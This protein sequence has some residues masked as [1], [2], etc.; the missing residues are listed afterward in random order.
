MKNAQALEWTHKQQ[1]IRRSFEFRS[2]FVALVWVLLEAVDYLDLGMPLGTSIAMVDL[3]IWAVRFL[4]MT[5]IFLFAPYYACAGAFPEREDQAYFLTVLV[6]VI[7]LTCFIHYLGGIDSS[8]LPCLY[9]FVILYASGIFPRNQILWITAACSLSYI[10]LFWFEFFEWIP[11]AILNTTELRPLHYLVR[12][13][14]TLCTVWIGGLIATQVVN[15]LSEKRSLVHLG[16]F[17]LGL[18]HEL[19]TP[20]AIILNEVALLRKHQQSPEL[21]I[22]KGQA[23]RVSNLLDQILSYTEEQRLD[24]V[25]LDLRGTV[26]KAAS[27]VIKSLEEGKVRDIQVV[28]DYHG[29]RVEVLGDDVQLQQG[30]INLIRNAIEAMDYQGT[31]TIRVGIYNVFWAQA[32]ILDQGVGMSRE[33]RAQAFEPFFTTKQRGRG[34]GLGLPITQRIIDDHR[35]NIVVSS[36]EGSGT[37]IRV[38]IP[39]NS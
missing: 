24:L 7:V 35:G 8:F 2:V 13:A 28:K 26:D 5:E 19:R 23:E 16:T 27:Y 9:L 1:Y 18:A 37:T 14:V 29:E 25:P 21:D 38:E 34:T 39:L 3:N 10:V 32:E 17:F 6:D 22:I 30:F 33:V 31:L 4:C 15:V 36:E 12:L 20:L 11:R